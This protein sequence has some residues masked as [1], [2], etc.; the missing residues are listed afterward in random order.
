MSIILL[1][2]VTTTHGDGAEAFCMVWFVVTMIMI[3]LGL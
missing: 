1:A 3:A 2:L